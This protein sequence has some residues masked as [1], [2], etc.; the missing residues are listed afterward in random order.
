VNGKLKVEKHVNL[1]TPN[2]AIV[3]VPFKYTITV[4]NLDTSQNSPVNGVQVIDVIPFGLVVDETSLPSECSYD[5]TK[6]LTCEV[7]SI[8]QKVDGSSNN[9]WTIEFSVK[10]QLISGK[11][12]NQVILV[13]PD[14]TDCSSMNVAKNNPKCHYTNNLAEAAAPILSIDKTA[15]ATEVYTGRQ[16]VY[17]I[18]VKN[19]GN[20]E[21]QSDIVMDDILPDGLQYMGNYAYDGSC[22]A[23]A[24]KVTCTR[25]AGLRPGNESVFDIYVRATEATDTVEN[26]AT[27]T[28]GGGDPICTDI[29]ENVFE[30]VKYE[31]NDP[32][33]CESAFT[34]KVHDSGAVGGISG[35][36]LPANAGG[37]MALKIIG[38]VSMIGMTSWL[39][40][41][42]KKAG[43]LI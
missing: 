42:R 35:G 33:R 37:M 13:H 1:T 36:A 41:F 28:R 30:T 40:L 17:R 21:T 32:A 38:T 3:G 22:R 14:A 26:T 23:D 19:V 34:I 9:K 31:V 11:I 20:I 39:L 43:S 18:A 24:L 6:Y 25:G 8:P 16:F 15:N 10:S 5:G 12:I 2:K 27:I 29:D 4:T 7:P